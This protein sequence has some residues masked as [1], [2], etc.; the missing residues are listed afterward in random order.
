MGHVG[1]NLSGF[2]NVCGVCSARC[3]TFMPDNQTPVPCCKACWDI[4]TVA[5]KLKILAEMRQARELTSICNLLN[6][7]VRH[8]SIL[9]GRRFEDSN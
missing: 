8:A 1:E 7:S 6:E 2:D 4:L 5:D 9:T 3:P